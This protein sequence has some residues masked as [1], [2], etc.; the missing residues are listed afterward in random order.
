MSLSGATT[1][2]AGFGTRALR[3][4]TLG[5][6]VLAAG[7]CPQD[8][9][10]QSTLRE[11]TSLGIVP[12]DVAFY[13]TSLRLKEQFDAFIG[14]KAFARIRSLPLVQEGLNAFWKEL[15]EHGT[16]ASFQEFH[17]FWKDPENRQLLDLLKDMISNE[18]FCY[19]DASVVEFGSKMKEIGFTLDELQNAAIQANGPAPGPA[20]NE[21][22]RKLTAE[23]D[24]LPFPDFVVGFRLSNG[25]AARQQIA[26]LE[27][28]AM[29]LLQGA[30]GFEGRLTR[31]SLAGTDY[32]TLKLDGSQIPWEELDLD[33]AAQVDPAQVRAL[34]EKLKK[35]T[36]TISLGVHGKY[37]LLSIGDTNAHLAKLAGGGKKLIDR[38]E[39]APVVKTAEKPLT[40]IAYVSEDL[41][42]LA[43]SQT[44]VAAQ[45]SRLFKNPTFGPLLASIVDEKTQAGLLAEL[46]A[47]E[48]EARSQMPDP[49]ATTAWSY[50]TPRGSE[51]FSYR[52][53]GG[54]KSLDGTQR[55]SILDHVG[56]SPLIAVARR[57]RGGLERHELSVRSFRRLAPHLDAIVMGV[58]P[59][60]YKD[61]YVKLLAELGPLS[62]R[63]D[64]TTR[65][66]FLPALA[67][68]QSAFVLDAKVAHRQW[69][70]QMPAATKPVAI[71]EVALVYGV[72]DAARL[73]E[74][75]GEYFDLLNETIAALGRVFP[76]VLPPIRIPSPLMQKTATGKEFHYDIAE[77]LGLV[78]DIRPTA[79]L[80]PKVAVLSLFAEQAAR[81]AKAAP[82]A[83]TVLPKRRDEPAASA[84]FVNFSGLIDLVKPWVEYGFDQHAASDPDEAVPAAVRDQILTVLDVLKCFRSSAG[85]AYFEGPA[86]VEFGETI[87]E[88]LP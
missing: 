46:T 6:A 57:T 10:A 82:L 62:A 22:L 40:S 1:R 84:S 34:I 75:C 17:D 27:R 66:K 44:D 35:V 45:L 85:I 52:W 58:I 29:P 69:H 7:F 41:D 16:D 28:L 61:V 60:P 49:S 12:D 4:A 68:G 74:A 39:L 11:Q 36:L 71:P 20:L 63:Y 14:S 26:R 78:P 65:T 53:K 38:P 33:E 67:D 59:E 3:A 64:A 73:E 70:P 87:F 88:D 43:R 15:A 55:L 47:I 42:R 51:S 80:E 83:P 18:V 86:L 81:L 48:A 8:A 30:Q 54:S 25:E 50:R 37:L 31:L 32:L 9:V 56:V 21:I 79:A 23:I 24:R 5:L 19:G 77:D 72:S 2:R 13:S 76:G